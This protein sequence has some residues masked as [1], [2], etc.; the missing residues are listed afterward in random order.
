M[1]TF[2]WRLVNF[3]SFLDEHRQI[4]MVTYLM[5]FGADMI[6]TQAGNE[7]FGYQKM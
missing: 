5:A 2:Q 1:I 4:S 7:P 6:E 3:P